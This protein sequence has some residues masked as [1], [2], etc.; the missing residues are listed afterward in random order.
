MLFRSSGVAWTTPNAGILYLGEVGYQQPAAAGVNQTWVRTGGGYNTSKF[1]SYADPGT[2]VDY[3][4][5]LYFVADRQL[6]QTHPDS[7]PGRGIYF[8][9]S[10][11]YA[12]PYANSISEYYEARLYARVLFDTDRMISSRS[13]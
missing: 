13:F 3:N 6:W 1:K 9:A 2:R 5:Y 10:A 8:G 11:M 7:S 12:P 4:H